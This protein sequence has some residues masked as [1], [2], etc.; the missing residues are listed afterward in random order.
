MNLGTKMD[1]IQNQ[2]DNYVITLM[3]Q[4]G[5]PASLMDFILAG[6]VVRIKNMK[7]YEYATIIMNEQKKSDQEQEEEINDMEDYEPNKEDMESEVKFNAHSR[8]PNEARE[9]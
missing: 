1:E 7:A 6:T 2:I 4:N 3:K 5:I 8:H 9:L